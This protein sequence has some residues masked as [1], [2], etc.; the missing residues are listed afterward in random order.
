MPGGAIVIVSHRGRYTGK[1]YRSPLEVIVED[2][3]R[4]EIFLLPARGRQSDWYRNIVAAGPSGVRF[5]GESFAADWRELS[6]EESSDALN[7]YA[8]VHPRWG[9]FILSGLARKHRLS[10][11]PLPAVADTLPVLA[12]KLRAPES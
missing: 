12:L 7:I 2:R 4:E 11:D 3:D 8:S 9:R 6:A 1:L 10:G 5:R